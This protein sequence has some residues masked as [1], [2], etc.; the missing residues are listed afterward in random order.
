MFHLGTL[1]AAPTIHSLIISHPQQTTT[2]LFMKLQQSALNYLL[3]ILPFKTPLRHH[4]DAVIVYYICFTLTPAA[5]GIT[6]VVAS[7]LPG[8]VTVP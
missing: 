8:V 1:G 2:I 7:A 4:C 3:S 6:E 5:T